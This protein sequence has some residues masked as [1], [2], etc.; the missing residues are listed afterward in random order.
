MK[1]QEAELRKVQSNRRITEDIIYKALSKQ[2]ELL[3]EIARRLK[4]KS[5]EEKDNLLKKIK[6]LEEDKNEILYKKSTEDLINQ[7]LMKSVFFS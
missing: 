6:N 4:Y 2:T 3:G 5:E 7:K 1:K